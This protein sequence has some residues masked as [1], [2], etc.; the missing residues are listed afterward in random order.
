MDDD[1]K[2]ALDNIKTPAQETDVLNGMFD[3]LPEEEQRLIRKI[4]TTMSLTSDNPT[5]EILKKLNEKHID[6]FLK[7][8]GENMRLSFKE[9]TQARIIS[10]VIIALV[11]AFLVFIVFIFRDNPDI[12]EKVIYATGG[13]VA[14]GIG[15]FGYA[16]S[17]S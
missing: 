15:G 3:E 17:K 8:S 12:V 6:T 11:L 16:K 9:R 14:G 2:N 7:D 13:F 10:I 1:V 4:T 5:A